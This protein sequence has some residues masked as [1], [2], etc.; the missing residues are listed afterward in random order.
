[1]QMQMGVAEGRRAGS[2][3]S[4]QIVDELGG[5]AKRGREEEGIEAVRGGGMWDRWD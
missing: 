4:A 2:V 5:E 1:M 3:R